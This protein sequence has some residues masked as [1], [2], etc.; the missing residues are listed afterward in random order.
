MESTRLTMNACTGTD[1]PR[2]AILMAVYEPR[3]DWL[4][5]Q[6]LSLNAQTYPNLVLY[7]RDDCSPTV[8]Y[9]EIQSCVQDCISAFPYTIQRNEKNLGSN[10]TFEWLTREAEGE[11]FA[12][13]DQDDVWLPE[14]IERLKDSLLKKQALLVC[15]DMYV[16]DENGMII[17][18][19][20]RKVRRHH[21]FCSGERLSRKLLFSNFVTG[22][23]MMVN[24]KMAKAAVPF[25]P[26]MVHDHY[27]ALWSA[28]HGKIYSESR[29]LI[30]YRIHGANQTNVMSGVKD[31][32]S[33]GEI[34]IRLSK[35][36][37]EWLKEHFPCGQ[38]TKEAINQG[39]IWSDARLRSWNHRGGMGTLWKYRNLNRFVS[40][41]ECCLKYMPNSV[42]MAA[43]RLARN[44]KV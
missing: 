31:K 16:I 38:E 39:L 32:R 6:L 11:Y 13:C 10:G 40:A 30:R 9:E 8:P 1:K 26:Y 24:S 42:F 37:F 12:Y 3:M 44:N 27:L 2:I 28:E 34:R 35:N 5:E 25:C 43:V 29:P 23:T 15:S 19:S 22:C 36:K 7:V 41:A 14:K 20:I 4:R 17:A 33:Y 18:D 21:V